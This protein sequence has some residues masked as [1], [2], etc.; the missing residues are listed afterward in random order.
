MNILEFFITLLRI[1][2]KTVILMG[3]F[4]V[5]FIWAVLR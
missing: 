1:M 2:I 5:A 4:F 3:A